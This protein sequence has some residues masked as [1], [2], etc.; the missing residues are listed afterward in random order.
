MVDEIGS[1]LADPQV[2]PANQAQVDAVRNILGWGGAA[3]A[4]G[5]GLRGLTGLGSFLGREVG[6]ATKTPQRQTFVRIPVPVK[7]HNRAERDAMLAA[8]QEENAVEKEA[9]FEK[10]AEGALDWLSQNIASGSG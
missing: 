2:G 9:S 1:L 5:A 4:A 10:L 7:V 6:D 3:L 8:D